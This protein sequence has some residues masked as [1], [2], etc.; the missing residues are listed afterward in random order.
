MQTG[1][2]PCPSCQATIA[3][4]VEDVLNGSAIVCTGCGLELKANTQTSRSALDALDR[5][6]T[7]TR[8]ARAHSASNGGNDTVPQP[9]R[10][11]GRRP[12]R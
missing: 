11:R 4:P 9:R 2:I 6:Y 7:E 5:W 8:D 10:V 3:L 1:Q 12:R